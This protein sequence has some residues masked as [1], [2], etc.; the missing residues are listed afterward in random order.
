MKSRSRTLADKSIDAMLAAIEVY[1]KPTFAYR[2]ESFAILAINSWELLLKARLLQ[3]ANNRLAV[4]LSYEHRQRADG[5]HSEK[6]YRKKSRS[7][8]YLSVGL[9]RAIDRLRDDFGDTTHPSV[10][11]NLELLCEVRDNA[12]HFINK[13]FDI[14]KLVQELGTACLRNYLGLV[15]R[16]FAIDLSAYNFFLMPLAFVG[17][18]RSVDAIT[19]NSSER[20]VIEYLRQ[21][22]A[23]DPEGADYSVALRVDLKF[24]RSKAV[25]AVPVVVSD[26]H[27]TAIA[28]RLSEEDIR[29]KY[30]WD[31]AI[32]TT[33]LKKRYA[34]FKET[35][36][37]HQLRRT[38]E[39]DDRF[40]NTRY[41]NPAKKS[42]IL[43]RFYNSNILQE[44]DKHYERDTPP[45]TTS[46]LNPWFSQVFAPE[47]RFHGP[48]GSDTVK[49]RWKGSHPHRF[50]CFDVLLRDASR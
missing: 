34:N 5:T 20:K 2:E 11:R 23:D 21:R 16:W 25:D 10:R 19:M 1:N 4:I 33:R 28:V 48:S 38:L 49:P 47:A 15:G 31:Y 32:L 18:G 35:K 43:K 24:S 12:V 26:A 8:T 45:A 17:V 46:F 13:G 22:I 39:S 6:L 37:Y 3:L 27:Q 50:Q 30:P 9:F 41:L 14:S 36:E 40:C 7:G 44:F 42:G 29:E